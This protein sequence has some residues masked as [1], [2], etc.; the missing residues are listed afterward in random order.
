MFTVTYLAILNLYLHPELSLST[1]YVRIPNRYLQLNM[2]KIQ[3]L[4][5]PPKPPPPITSS[6]CS[7]KK[8]L[9]IIYL[10]PFFLLHTSQEIP[11]ALNSKQY[12]KPTNSQQLHYCHPGLSHTHLIFFSHSSHH[13]GLPSMSTADMQAVGLCSCHFLCLEHSS[14]DTY[15][16]SSSPHLCSNPVFSIS[17]TQFSYSTSSPHKSCHLLTHHIKFITH[18]ILFIASLW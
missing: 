6:R 8:H 12:P 10:T 4:V 18:Y 7:C 13:V 17:P 2:A 16:T 5:S 11:L 1:G 9:G 3:F 15:L 14:P